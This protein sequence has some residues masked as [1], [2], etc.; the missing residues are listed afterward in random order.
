MDGRSLVLALKPFS[1]GR[2]IIQFLTAWF[3]NREQESQLLEK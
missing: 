2:V 3:N 1:L